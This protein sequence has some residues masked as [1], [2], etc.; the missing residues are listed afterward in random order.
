MQ[1]KSNLFLV[2]K[3]LLFLLFIT[4]KNHVLAKPPNMGNFSLPTSQEPAPFFSFGQNIVDKKQIIVSYEPSYLYSQNQ[5]ILE[6]DP[7]ILYGITDSASILFTLPI[8]LRYEYD[9]KVLSGIGD[10]AVDLE[11]AYYNHDTSK[12]SDQATIIYSSSFPVSTLDKISKKFDIS[13]RVSGFSRKNAA[14][15]FNAMTY[16]LGASYSRTTV[17]WYGFIAPGVLLIG[18]QHSIQQGAQYYY[19]GGIGHNIRS[20]EKKYI[21]LG[22]IELN[23]QYSEKT[24]IGSQSAPNTG[25][26]IIYVTPSLWFSTPK[27][28]VQVGISLPISQHWNGNQSNISY[29]TGT[30]ITWTIR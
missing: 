27:L 1:T 9:K 10:L 11:Y 21:F 16:F 15:S 5:R 19:N 8:A 22:L 26:N 12:Y 29:Y 7:S 28:I 23:G 13:N 17:N 30:M 14:T 2:L 24:R 20:K 4:Y 3:G 18:E 25:G 6:G